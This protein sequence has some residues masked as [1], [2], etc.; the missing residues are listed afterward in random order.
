MVPI[1]SPC[2]VLSIYFECVQKVL[3]FQGWYL[4]HPRCDDDCF[5]K[6]SKPWSPG[7]NKK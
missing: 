6:G 5:S 4:E 2:D 7:D 1:G 3:M